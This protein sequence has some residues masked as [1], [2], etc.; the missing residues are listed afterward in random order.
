MISELDWIKHATP[1]YFSEMW[2]YRANF[3][4]QPENILNFRNDV[5][6]LWL[7]DL[8][9]LAVLL[10]SIP[11]VIYLVR[12]RIV[13]SKFVRAVSV[14]FFGAVFMTTPL[15]K[16]IWD[17]VGFLQK[18]QFPW[19]WMG[20]IS[21]FGAIFASNGIFR[22]AEALKA[23][24]N[25][26]LPIGL[27]AILIVFVFTSA[28]IVKGAVYHSR[29]E[30]NSQFETLADAPSFDCWWTI[31]AKSSAFDQTEKARAGNREIE[32]QKWS[33]TEKIFTAAAGEP[34]ISTLAVFY[35]PRWRAAINDQPVVE[36]SPTESGLISFSVPAERAEIRVYFQETGFV[37]LAF[38]V[39]AF[40]WA[41]VLCLS[42]FGLFRFFL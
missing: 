40:G 12:R 25:I 16:I 27:G 24:K 9:L 23:S 6:A 22:A 15:S 10:L 41:A 18:V 4:F 2:D 13:A 29:D 39:S 30:F 42:G 17:N 31:W 21:A 20:I 7:A 3:L 19:R 36:I 8:M 28:F 35:Y 32:I 34:E 33:A 1:E 5:L 38:Y 14:V 37:R 26:L 11:T